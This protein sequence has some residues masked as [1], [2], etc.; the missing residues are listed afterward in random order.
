MFAILAVALLFMF[1]VSR[2]LKSRSGK[3]KQ[4]A[5]EDTVQL[6]RLMADP[7]S[8]CAQRLA[9]VGLDFGALTPTHGLHG[10][11]HGRSTWELLRLYI[12]VRW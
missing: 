10:G 5:V 9:A 4:Q 8:T 2:V 1:L 3:I 11:G 12:H 6:E 7:Q